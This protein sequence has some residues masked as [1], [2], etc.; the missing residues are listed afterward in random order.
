MIIS[1][2]TRDFFKKEQYALY[3][4]KDIKPVNK[5]FNK[6]SQKLISKYTKSYKYS[7]NGNL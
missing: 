2:I 4:Q 7:Y 1:F 6:V 5:E 3:D